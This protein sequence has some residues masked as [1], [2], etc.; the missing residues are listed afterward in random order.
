[1]NTSPRPARAHPPG[2]RTRSTWL[3]ALAAAAA[4]TTMSACAGSDSPD[5]LLDKARQSLSERQPRTAEIHLKNLLQKSENAEARYLLGSIYAG[6]GDLASAEKEYRRAFDLG[7]ERERSLPALMATLLALGQP[8]RV[9]DLSHDLKLESPAAHGNALAITGN[10]LL[11]LRK[12]EEATQ[13][14]KEALTVA[15]GNT[16]ARIGLAA[17]QAGNDREGARASLHKLLAEHPDTPEALSLLANLDIADGRRDEAVASLEKLVAVAPRSPDAQLRL[18]ALALDRGDLEAARRHHGE[19]SR[20]APGSPITLHQKAMIELRA[21]DQAAA[22]RAIDEALRKAPDYLP[23]VALGASLH[24]QLNEFEQAERLSR[25]LVDRAPNAIQGY[26]LLGAT[27]LRMNAPDRAL[28]AVRRP[29]ERGAQDAM[30]LAIAGEAALKTNDAEAATRYFEQASKLDPQ[31]PRKLTGLAMAQ[32][33]SGERDK[34]IDGLETAVELDAT[35]LRADIALVG[36]LLRDRKFDDA[37]HAVDRMEK[38]APDSP[39]PAGLRGAVLAA[40]NDEPGARK[41][42]EEALKR[43][44]KYFAAAANLA[45]LELRAGRPEAAA[46]HYQK[47]LAADPRNAQA[48]VAL[49]VLSARQGAP[50]SEVLAILAKARDD[51]PGAVLPVVAT[52]RYMLETNTASEAL[53]ML[54]AA[55]NANPENPQLLDT[56]A[57]TLLSSNQHTQAIATWERL[58]R[59]NPNAWQIQMRIADAQRA[60]GQTEAVLASLRK[61]ERM[62]PEAAEPKLALAARLVEDKRADEARK[63]AAQLRA[64]ERHALVGQVLE[65]DIAAAERNWKAAITAYRGAF[66][67]ARTV[68]IGTKLVRTLRADGQNAAADKVLGDWL[69]AEP[70]NIALRMFAGEYEVS[71]EQWRKAWDHYSVALDRQPDNPIALNNAAWALYQL[72]DERAADLARRAWEGAPN[73][74]A[75]LDTYGVILSEGSDPKKGVELLR[76]AVTAAPTAAQIRLHYAEALARS[77]DRAAARVEVETVMK[78]VTEGPIAE[79]ARALS[80]RL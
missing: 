2:R 75:I 32:L 23:A 66:G 59:V 56:L 64:S 57:T 9:L 39:V 6:A 26:R 50:R 70:D 24:L 30:L 13:T 61:A 48:R 74:P 12:P 40:R 31:D 16:A 34:A 37:L 72:K 78:A 3:A 58:L 28:D 22:K 33:A 20:L 51:N 44:P 63:I 77:G 4:L 47:V 19:L 79:R 21:G 54:Q 62:A 67:T 73:N 14:F 71:R 27:Y 60:A 38:K 69:A 46:G 80:G 76:A 5:A 7:Y 68:P 53:P 29:I 18:A 35:G 43:D 10:A 65:G 36:A 45:N 55:V 52:A 42:F 41:A 11:Q 15:P 49:A 17:L 8:Q 1:M 25:Q